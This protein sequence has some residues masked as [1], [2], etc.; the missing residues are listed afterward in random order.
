MYN[1]TSNKDKL[2]ETVLELTFCLSSKFSVFLFMFISL[3][4]DIKGRKFST[5]V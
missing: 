5:K 4:N 3:N 1:L 2:N